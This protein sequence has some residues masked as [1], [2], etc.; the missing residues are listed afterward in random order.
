LGLCDHQK[1]P[2][3]KSSGVQVVKAPASPLPNEFD[4]KVPTASQVGFACS[5]DFFFLLNHF[6]LAHW[7]RNFK[8]LELSFED[9]TR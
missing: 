9:T 1:G 7:Q 6:P 2:G 3:F 5:C 8:T 4:L